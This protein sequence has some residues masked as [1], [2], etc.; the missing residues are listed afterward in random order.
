MVKVYY[1][2]FY[3]T[4]RLLYPIMSSFNKSIAEWIVAFVLSL[5]VFFDILS[6]LRFFQVYWGIETKMSYPVFLVLQIAVF[7][8]NYKLY[9]AEEN[10]KGINKM[11][12]EKKGLR[13]ITSALVIAFYWVSIWLLFWSIENLPLSV[14]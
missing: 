13:L 9:V 5:V 1:F 6:S 2:L 11:F 8:F 14:S 4:F 10:Y 12:N 7:Y 3:K